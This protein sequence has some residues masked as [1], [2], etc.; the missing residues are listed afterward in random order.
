MARSPLVS[1]ETCP[2][3]PAAV[4]LDNAGTDRRAACRGR[5]RWGRPG[6]ARMQREVTPGSG[7]RA[8]SSEVVQGGAPVTGWPGLRPPSAHSTTS[9]SGIRPLATLPIRSTRQP[10]SVPAARAEWPGPQ[11]ADRMVDTTRAASMASAASDSVPGNS[12]F[13][14]GKRAVQASTTPQATRPPASPVLVVMSSGPAA[15]ASD[16]V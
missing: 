13:G 16:E 1:G 12:V 8:G 2:T 5:H 9:G 4:P 6:T 3:S 10:R 11:R 7:R 14:C 15:S